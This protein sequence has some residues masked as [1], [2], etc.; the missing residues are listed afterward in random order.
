M[1]CGHR[2]RRRR[3]IAALRVPSVAR[4]ARHPPRDRRRRRHVDRRGASRGHARLPR[5]PGGRRRRKGDGAHALPVRDRAAHCRFAP[6]CHR[7]AASVS[8]CADAPPDPSAAYDIV[9]EGDRFLYK[10]VRLIAGTLVGVGMGLLPPE[11]V[12]EA[13]GTP[14]AGESDSGLAPDELRRRGVVVGRAAAA[15]TEP[16]A[17]RVRD[18]PPCC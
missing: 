8:P 16:R 1:A 13:L 10:M 2:R 3:A 9:V 18:R 14:H 12:V 17:R 5:L 7:H 11:A 4:A 15:A 6:R